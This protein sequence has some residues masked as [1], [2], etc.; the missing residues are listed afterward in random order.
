[1][2][3]F[4]TPVT[5]VEDDRLLRGNGCYVAD[6]DLADALFVTYVTSIEPHAILRSVD[7]RAAREAPGVVD[8]VVGA[9]VDLGP[10]PPV[11]PNAPMGMARHMLARD[12]VRFVGEA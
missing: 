2:P 12:R 1:M 9:D 11:N 3:L 4:G 10:V 7:V 8:V 6:L 5:R